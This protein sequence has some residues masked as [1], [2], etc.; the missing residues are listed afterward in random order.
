MSGRWRLLCQ[1]GW[2]LHDDPDQLLLNDDVFQPVYRAVEDGP[3]RPRPGD[4]AAAR[5][6]ALPPGHSRRGS[7]CRRRSRR[8]LPHE[9]PVV[10]RRASSLSRSRPRL[11]AVPAFGCS[12]GCGTARAGPA[13]ELAEPHRDPGLDE[14]RQPGEVP[15]P[16]VG[17]G[18][19][20]AYRRPVDDFADLL[21]QGRCGP[22]VRVDRGGLDQGQP[23]DI[24]PGRGRRDLGTEG[25]ES[26][27]TSHGDSQR[28][29]ERPWPPPCQRPAGRRSAES[30]LP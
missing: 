6:R 14:G 23:G 18:D 26:P 19:D 24:R 4:H 30:E 16:V 11:G 13:G 10:T 7:G 12:P 21:H 28:P 25:N 20:S 17:V 22:G 8:R 3:R 9:L 1:V 29:G 5:W 2:P 15:A 27:T